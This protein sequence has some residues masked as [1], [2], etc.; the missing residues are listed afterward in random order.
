MAKDKKKQVEQQ[1]QEKRAA[2]VSERGWLV[3]SGLMVV[4]L[5]GF[6]IWRLQPVIGSRAYLWAAGLGV[7]T[8]LGL[9][10]SYY[11]LFKKE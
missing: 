11:Y 7:F 9:G 6:V 2:P 1:P 4:L 10:V 8:L 3:R 5:V